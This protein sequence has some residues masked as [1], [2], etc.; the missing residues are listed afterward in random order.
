VSV[1]ITFDLSEA[2]VEPNAKDAVLDLAEAKGL[3]LIF[4]C[5]SGSCGVC[6]HRVTEGLELLEARGIVEEDTH[7]RCYDSDDIRLVCQAKF[8]AGASGLLALE[9]APEVVIKDE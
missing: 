7:A 2:S 9:P 1:K 4:G 5:R 3:K 8:K 6:R